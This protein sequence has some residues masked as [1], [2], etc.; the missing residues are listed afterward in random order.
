MHVDKLIEYE[1]TAIN[2]NIIFLFLMASSGIIFGELANSEAIVLDGAFSTILFLTIFLA[3]YIQKKTSEPKS[4]L[5]PRGK[6]QLNSLYILFKIMLLFGIL[7]YSL[8]ESVVSIGSFV[9]AGTEPEEIV[10]IYAN[11]Y[12]VVKLISFVFAYKIYQNYLIKTKGKSQLLKI[13][14]SA[15]LIDGLITVSIFIGF[16]T[17]G[18]IDLIAPIT[19]SIIL[20]FLSLFLM[21]RI[22]HEFR[23]TLDLILGKRIFVKRENYYKSL[24]TNYFPDLEI[25]DLYIQYLGKTTVVSI[26]GSFSGSKTVND[27]T[28]IEQKIKDI[29]YKEYGKIL[30]ELYWDT[31]SLGYKKKIVK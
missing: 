29:M 23:E 2:K 8:L 24:F 11:I 18:R 5:Y 28:R 14:K 26:V 16:Q 4:F 7:L 21:Y 30:L 20:F 6:W 3:K 17:L 25:L 9:M 13:E 19:D 27:F 31:K 15:V 10:Q 1:N 12:Y 22:I